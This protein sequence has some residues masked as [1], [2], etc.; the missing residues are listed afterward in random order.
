[1]AALA[2]N[3]IPTAVYDSLV[4][5]VDKHLDLLHRY[6]ALRKQLLGVDQLHMYDMYTPLAPAD[7]Q[8]FTS[9]LATALQ[10]LK[11]F[12]PDYLKHVKTAFASRWIDVVENQGK[13]SG[14]YSSECMIPRHT[15]CWT[16]RI[17]LI[18]Y[19]R[20]CTKCTQYA[21]LL[22]DTSALSVWWLF[23]FRGGNASTTN[24]NLLTNYF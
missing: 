18:I 2:A 17:I 11:I 12:S 24:E 5:S 21:L 20:W 14:A 13:R 19:I 22:H 8:L 23:N 3:Q 9:R 7:D 16:G 4:T 1:M 10:A 15:C 6:V